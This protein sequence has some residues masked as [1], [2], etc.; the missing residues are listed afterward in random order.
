MRSTR[1]MLLAGIAALALV[2]GNGLASAQEK[3]ESG[4]GTTPHAAQ[5]MKIGRAHV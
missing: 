1:T 3:N 4:K 2:A 5:Q